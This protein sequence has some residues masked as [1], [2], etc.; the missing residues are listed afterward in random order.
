MASSRSE[1]EIISPRESLVLR[2]LVR[3]YTLTEV[4]GS[5]GLPVPTVQSLYS[6]MCRKLHLHDRPAI[7]EYTAAIGL[8]NGNGGGEPLTVEASKPATSSRLAISLKSAIGALQTDIRK[9]EKTASSSV[10]I[11]TRKKRLARMQ[12]E[13]A[14]G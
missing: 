13:R 12:Q 9:L 1:P 3:G 8:L 7:R 14:T 6:E 11:A 4:A 10:V 2:Y 5:L